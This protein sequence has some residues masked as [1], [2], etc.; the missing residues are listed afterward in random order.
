MSRVLIVDDDPSIRRLLATLSKREGIH[1]D[2]AADG[3][4]AIA[5]LQS[6]SYALVLLDLM[7]PQ[8][9]GFAVIEWLG[10]HPPDPKPVVFVISAY[11][12]PMYR[13]VDTSVVAGVLHKPFDV[14]DVGT[15]LRHVT[16]GWDEDLA[17]ALRNSRERAIRDF[18]EAEHRERR[19]Q[20]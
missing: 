12:D 14:G 11:A 13:S 4:E 5:L 7:M 19:R 8:V 18:I 15:L 3:A 2:S 17:A 10:K 20:H 9:N 16:R 1:A 6:H